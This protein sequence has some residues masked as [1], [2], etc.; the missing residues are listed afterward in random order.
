[1]TIKEDDLVMCTVKSLEGT[2]VFVH[3]EGDGEGSISLSEIAAGRIRNLREYVVPNKKIVCKVLKIV[4]NQVQ[5]SLRRVTGNERQE[6][7]ERYKKEKSFMSILKTVS[8]EPEKLAEKI[9]ETKPLWEFFDEARDNPKIIHDVL[10]KDEAQQLEKILSEKRDKEKEVKRT[11]IIKSDSNSGVEDIKQILDIKGLDIRYL[12]SSQFT[13][14][15]KGKEFKDADNLI[16]QALKE[17]EKKAK[18]L[19]AI[20]EIKEK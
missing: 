10:K 8:K 20:L 12:G 3:I 19:K 6:I 9:K 13:I 15:A 1:M 16:Q 14:I 4:N 11:I 18:Q 5:L 17:I 7:E 2:T